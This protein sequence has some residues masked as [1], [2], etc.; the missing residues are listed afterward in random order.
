MVFPLFQLSLIKNCTVY[1]AEMSYVAGVT[2]INL[3]NLK[4]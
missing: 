4:T 3:K 2:K 1:V